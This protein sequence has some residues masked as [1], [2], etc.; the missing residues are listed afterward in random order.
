[1]SEQDISPPPTS[2][3]LLS[4]AK[5]ISFTCAK[6]NK[7]YLDCKRKDKN[8]AACLEQGNA[9]TSCTIDL[10]KDL[11]EKAPE[12][13]KAYCECMDYYSHNFL[14]CRK[15]QKAFEEKVPPSS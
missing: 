8:P 9:V 13:L 11:S 14:K 4:V 10:L 15:E 5:H 7:A 2:A 3:V 6:P 12:E 1:M